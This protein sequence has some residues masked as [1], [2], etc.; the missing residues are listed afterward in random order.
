M[1]QPVLNEKQ[2]TQL[3]KYKSC[4][5]D[6]SITLKYVLRPF[7]NWIIQFFPK[8][9][10]PNLITIFGLICQLLAFFVCMYYSPTFS[11]PL[12]RWVF[13]FNA[14]CVFS[15]QTFDNLD[16]KQA[17]RTG[18]CSPLGE[19]F[20]HG[21]DALTCSLGTY[22]WMATARTGPTSAAYILLLSGYL[23]FLTATWEEYFR[24][25]LFLGYVN[26]PIEGLLLVIGAQL[27]GFVVGHDWFEISVAEHVGAVWPRG[28]AMVSMKAPRM[29]EMRIGIAFVMVSVVVM[30][31]STIPNLLTT[32]KIVRQK[33]YNLLR[34]ISYLFP[35][36][37]ILGCGMIWMEMSPGNIFQQ[38][39]HLFF[40]GIGINCTYV[41]NHLTLAF[42]VQ[43]SYRIFYKTAF[44]LYVA[45]ANAAL[46][47]IMGIMI[48]EEILLYIYF[49]LGLLNYLTFVF[50]VVNQVASFLEIDVLSVSYLHKKKE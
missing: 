24:G 26:G 23:P 41:I 18:A 2:L 22:M 31:L 17:R 30:S 32:I 13:L 35:T 12:P 44:I 9:I 8:S 34:A 29:G 6:N 11:E 27:F 42:L 19:L 21:V 10:A 49:A 50:R 40:L 43:S 1:F 38:H 20:D 5:A 33:K 39:P 16:G 46:G 36:L 28:A 25:G 45:T 4:G 3:S 37:S 15:Y 48:P 7:H 47:N 14:V